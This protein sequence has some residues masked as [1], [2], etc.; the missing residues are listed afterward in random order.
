MA[1][2]IENFR[3]NYKNPDLRSKFKSITGLE[4]KGN[5]AAFISFINYIVGEANLEATQTAYDRM[6]THKPLI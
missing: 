5:E 1:K 2:A 3:K 6:T 4:V